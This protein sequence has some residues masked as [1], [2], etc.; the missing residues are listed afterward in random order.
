MICPQCTREVPV[1]EA[2]YLSMYTC[3]NCQA[4][5]FIDMNGQP[6]FGDMSA[7]AQID[8]QSDI[9][10]EISNEV[11]AE[12]TLAAPY[13][14]FTNQM[15]TEVNPFEQPAADT[16][17]FGTAATEITDFA[18]QDNTISVVSYDLKVTGL[19]TKE[20]M[21]LF[22]EA[23]EDSKFG[24]IA[25]D[26]FSTIKNGQCE[27]KDLNPIQ[28]FVLAKRI[29]FLDIEMEWKQNVQI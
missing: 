5:Y 11:T 4:V 20:T 9:I 21:A 24:W 26:I 15:N 19:D 28:A 7:S 22:K 17:V 6:E 18:N 1:T 12:L 14:D 13:A 27:F 3:A 8:I 2:Q 29:Q 10:N 16:S 23:L 25:L